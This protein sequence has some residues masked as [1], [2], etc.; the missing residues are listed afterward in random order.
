MDLEPHKWTCGQVG[1]WLEKIGFK[2]YENLFVK[3]HAIDGLS[4]LQLTEK[5]LKDP[6]L[7]LPRLG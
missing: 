6:P 1:N 7:S 2:E 5:D 4:L 3:K